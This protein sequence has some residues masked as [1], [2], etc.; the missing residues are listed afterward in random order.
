MNSRSLTAPRV[1][2]VLLLI[3]ISSAGLFM[4]QGSR[5]YKGRYWQNWYPLLIPVA[6]SNSTLEEEIYSL[7]GNDVVSSGSTVLEYSDYHDLETLPLRDFAAGKGPYQADPR[8]DPFMKTVHSYFYQGT[9][10]IFYLPSTKT[11]LEYKRLF[12]ASPVMEE[13]AWKLPDVNDS[14][15][16]LILSAGVIVLLCLGSL[17][18][19]ITGAS[20]LAAGLILLQQGHCDV[21]PVLGV[22][23]L[24]LRLALD[25]SG[26]GILRFLLPVVPALAAWFAGLLPDGLLMLFIPVFIS[27]GGSLLLT[28]KP[29][30][31]RRKEKG[32]RRHTLRGRDHSL[33]DPVS[34]YEKKTVKTVVKE[35]PS[36][37]L[38]AAAS[39]CLLAVLTGGVVEIALPAPVPAA[40]WTRGAWD[41]EGLVQTQDAGELP[42]A[43]EYIK[44]RAYQESFAYGA[45]YA[46]PVP[47]SR[48]SYTD[49]SLEGDRVRETQR[50]VQDYSE[51][52]YASRLELMG[53]NG[54]GRL[55]ASEPAPSAVVLR[56]FE[57]VGISLQVQIVLAVLIFVFVLIHI[58]GLH[59]TSEYRGIRNSGK[60]MNRR[61]QQAA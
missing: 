57:T 56:S 58:S 44:H 24:L 26:R 13:A 30:V 54:A 29:R 6:S 17:R 45:V 37:L 1:I 10:E 14:L 7:A 9:Y 4:L 28:G 41:Y 23:A 52:W 47:G 35:G 31:Y 43:A 34:L 16:P 51:S 39:V 49:Y 15:L 48:I 53:K 60:F 12:L 18:F 22:T 33:F 38:I 8:I 27:F 11:P 20:I 5:D 61:K 2:T 50:S 21:L 19:M 42:G 36:F 25:G 3:I 46:L 40:G 55:L 32:K 59:H